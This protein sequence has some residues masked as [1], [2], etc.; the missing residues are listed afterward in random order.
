MSRGPAA[1][2]VFWARRAL[3]DC[4][5]ETVTMGFTERMGLLDFLALLGLPAGL[6]FLEYLVPMVQWDLRAL[7]G[8]RAILVALVRRVPLVH[9]VLMERKA[10]TAR[11]GPRDRRVSR[12]ITDA[13]GCQVTPVLLVARVKKVCRVGMVIPVL[14]VWTA[15]SAGLVLLGHQAQRESLASMAFREHQVRWASPVSRVSQASPDPTGL[16]ERK[17]RRAYQCSRSSLPL[18]PCRCLHR[19]VHRLRE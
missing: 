14:Q 3:L 19:R 6:V 15:R 17:G 4:R 10:W 2:R 5:E 7:L 13:M 18:R 9:P 8:S 16:L 1:C 11:G 12:A